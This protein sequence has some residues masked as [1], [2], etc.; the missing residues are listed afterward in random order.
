M[1]R[2]RLLIP[3][4]AALFCLVVF[5]VLSLHVRSQEHYAVRVHLEEIS[6]NL[7]YNLAER[8]DMDI[9]GLQRLADRWVRAGGTVEADWRA[10]ARAYV[11]DTAELRAVQWANPE[12]RLEWIEPLTGNEAALGLD[13]LFEEYRARA[14]MQAVDTRR[15]NNSAAI[16]FVQGGTGFL[17]YFPL[18]VDGQFDG[19]IVGV[20]DVANMVSAGLPESYTDYIA[21]R[22]NEAGDTIASLG[23]PISNRIVSTHSVEL[24]GSVW[25]VEVYPAAALYAE[26]FSS[27]PIFLLVLGVLVAAGIGAGSH[28]VLTGQIRQSELALEREAAFDELERNRERMALAVRGSSDGFWDWDLAERALYHS[29]RLRAL[30]GYDEQAVTMSQDDYSADV[31]PDDRDRNTAALRAHLEKGHDYD[32]QIRFVCA[33]GE[34]RWF[35]ARGLA[36]RRDGKAVR[37]AG[38]ITDITDL[39]AAR[40][41]A[42]A[43]NRAKSDFLANMSHE[44]RT[45]MNGILGMA[46]VLADKALPED[47]H[48]K[49]DIIVRS[50]DTLMH[51]LDDILD[52]S[53]IEAGQIELEDVAFQLDS[54]AARVAALYADAAEKKGI[55]FEI[56]LPAGEPAAR[57]GDPLR[58]A[59]IAN[60]LVANAIKFTNE[61]SVRVTLGPVIADTNDETDTG[62]LVELVVTDT[63]IGMSDEQCRLVFDKFVQAD[64]STTRRFGGTGLGL[65]ICKG[66][67]EQMGGTISVTSTAGQGTRFCVR[68]PMP[69]VEPDTSLSQRPDLITL[70]GALTIEDR[71]VRV[72]AAE[73]NLTNRLVLKAYLDKMKVDLE[74][75]ENGEE[76]VAAFRREHFDIVLLDIQMPVMNGEDALS[77]MRNFERADSRLPTP[78]MAL[79]ANVMA[80]QVNRYA[81]LGFDAHTEKPL[82]P[83][84]LERTMRRLLRGNQIRRS[85]RPATAS[86]N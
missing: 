26:E 3:L 40:D 46:R 61:G 31:H 15:P 1:P 20:F 36:H 7:Q 69:A 58:F 38:S 47:V 50:G 52:L 63:G 27:I 56:D 9:A 53:K 66:L 33:N 54:I 25:T 76:A 28:L 2:Y 44:I 67:T 45:P 74:M 16:H 23:T 14:V 59:Q 37:M 13:I 71:P 42:D 65:A 84:A 77:E 4:S 12:F 86:P 57:F 85:A 51:L 19:L 24:P 49:L 34:Y 39:V 11:N 17:A 48:A 41:K 55:K 43:A 6:T 22:V 81:M 30:L 78:V 10:D 80:D 21:I 68:V 60:N 82:S 29:P 83:E 75:V 70:G 62:D 18:F 5:T 64:S 35:R 73:D 72:L 32:L 79:T 8:V